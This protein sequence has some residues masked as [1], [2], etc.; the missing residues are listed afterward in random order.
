MISA[1]DPHSEMPSSNFGKLSSYKREES[2]AASVISVNSIS[3]DRKQIRKREAK[4]A[5]KKIKE[6]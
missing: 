2:Y 4:A 1:M 6:S 3:P 5:N